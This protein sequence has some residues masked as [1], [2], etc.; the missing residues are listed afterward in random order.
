VSESQC[1]K[2]AMLLSFF[3]DRQRKDAIEGYAHFAE[4]KFAETQLPKNRV[5]YLFS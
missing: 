3:A 5:I 4:S 1:V 2:A